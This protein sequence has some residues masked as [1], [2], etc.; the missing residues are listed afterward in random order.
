MAV[1]TIA[2]RMKA[3][4]V[5]RGIRQADMAD[6]LGFNDRQ[7]IS[8][9]ETGERRVSAD[10]LMRVVNGLNVPL[11]Y[12]TDP[13]RLTGEGRFSWRQD[14]GDD[15][16]LAACEQDAGR[17]IAAFHTLAPQVGHDLPLMRRALN[18]NR[19]SRF[20]HA[21]AAGERFAVDYELGDVP[22]QRLAEAMERRLGV[23]VLMAD[24][25]GEVSG[26]ACRLPDL[27]TVLINRSEV[28]GRRH[29]DLAHELF[30]ILTWNEMPPRHIERP[31]EAGD[32]R[33]EK[34][35]DNF[36]GAVLMP[37]HAVERFGDWAQMGDDEL[38]PRLNA[39][40]DALLVTAS[41]L[42]WR[43]AALGLLTQGRARAVPEAALRNNGRAAPVIDAPPAFSPSFVQVIG[44]A[45]DAGRISA[46]RA[47][48][49]VGLAIDDLDALFGAHG[50]ASPVDL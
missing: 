10:E 29:F 37:R 25:P 18:L 1:E 22:A 15:A 28:A 31:G 9:I 30:H 4:R 46:R 40:A 13:F 49:L 50:L 24:L 11:D 45:I 38:V 17:W 47:A 14:D 3:L 23:L 32:N 12:F 16:A 35:A 34:L 8:A 39:A 44:A 42:R 33:V 21:M 26:A 27:D 41:A 5:E 7:T 2:A 48:R 19:H 43:L 36:A 6:L 20:E